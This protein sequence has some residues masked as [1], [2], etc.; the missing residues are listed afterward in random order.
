MTTLRLLFAALLVAS[1]G[2]AQTTD[3]PFPTPI[4]AT[5]GVIVV[6]VVEFASIPDVDGQPA[7]LMTM[8]DEPGTRRTFVSDMRGIIYSVGYGGG[9]VTRFLDLTDP[10]WNL[11]VQAQGR[12]RGLQS[13]AFHPQFAQAG[14]PGYG[15][16]YTWLDTDDNETAA[17]F[18]PGGGNNAHHTVLLEWT[19]RNAA[20]ASFEGEGPRELARFEQPFAN[21]NGGHMAFRPEAVPGDPDYGL[22]Y[23]GVGDGGSAGDPLNDAQNLR[24]GF[25][26][27]LR[28]DPLGSNSANGRYGIPAENPFV[29]HPEALP[30]I[31]A[32]GLRNPQRF[33]W[34]PS[35]G[36]LFLADVG[37]NVVEKLTLVP[38]GANLGWNVWEGSFRYV[39]ETRQVRL[40]GQRGDPSVTF[41]VAE[42]AQP[43]PREDGSTTQPL[44]NPQSAATGVH[45]FRDGSIPQLQNRV[46]WGDMPQGELFHIDADELP[47]GGQAPIRR[48]LLRHGGQT[49]TLLE[50]IQRKNREQGREPATRTDMRFGWGPDGQV[51]LL[52]KYDGTIRLL[53]PGAGDRRSQTPGPG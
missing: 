46:L 6:D 1:P 43:F 27:L 26:K 20:S 39:D 38:A 21:H 37:Q 28:I 8:L 9:P 14:A 17:D 49:S 48:V 19:A 2:L 42:Y 12:E 51:M 50:L 18:R 29:G 52:N 11:R 22:L 15:K 34:D 41:P 40:D 33:A 31:Y 35:T 4:S 13:F 45:V 3:S 25:G 30:E 47:S 23:V 32:Y 53:V 7:R 36:R 16:I 44:L 10:A 24:S 5:D